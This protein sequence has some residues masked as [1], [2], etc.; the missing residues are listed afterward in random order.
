MLRSDNDAHGSRSKLTV[1]R[2]DWRPKRQNTL[3]G[4][5][6]HALEMREA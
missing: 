6:P 2:A 1:A 4:F 3:S 5:D